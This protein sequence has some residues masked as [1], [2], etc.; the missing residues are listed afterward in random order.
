MQ[1]LIETLREELG[2]LGLNHNIE[3]TPIPMVNPGVGSYEALSQLEDVQVPLKAECNA[4][5]P[6]TT[7]QE[8]PFKVTDQKNQQCSV[9]LCDY[10]PT[11]QVRHLPCDHV[12]HTDCIK[13]WFDLNSKCPVCKSDLN[14]ILAGKTTRCSSSSA[15][16]YNDMVEY[17]ANHYANQSPYQQVLNEINSLREEQD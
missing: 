16:R 5:I 6:T 11:D 2:E 3:I 7:Y 10:E 9:C 12:F 17:Y 4:Q 13:Q 1:N 15:A 8:L 14:S